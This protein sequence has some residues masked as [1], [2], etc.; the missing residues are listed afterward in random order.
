MLPILFVHWGNS[1]YL[2]YSIYQARHFN[3]ESRII[4][5]GD[6]SNNKYKSIEHYNL[7]E[8]SNSADNFERIYKHMC[9]FSYYYVLF[10]F[11]RWFIIKDFLQRNDDIS[12]FIIIDS[13]VLIYCNVSEAFHP[14]LNNK[15]TIH[16]KRGP[17][18]TYMKN[19]N[20][21]IEFCDFI[22]KL[23]TDKT[24]FKNLLDTYEHYKLQKRPG[25]IDDMYALYEFSLAFPD[26]IGNTAT[27]IHD[28]TFDGTL[29]TSEGFEFNKKKQIKN[30]YWKK[31][32]PYGNH[33]D[34][35][36]FIRFNAIH[37]QSKAKSLMHR[38]YFGR[39]LFFARLYSEFYYKILQPI[40]IIYSKFR[41]TK[42]ND[43]EITQ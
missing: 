1:D 23:Y 27:I 16:G 18:V 33:L 11:K 42:T 37:F 22:V 8:Y 20:T 26:N 3:P 7:A 5:L 12:N 19:K 29:N 30:I 41:Q 14:F 32:L 31:N 21:I 10:W 40:K 17:H 28:T 38:Y 13:D 15:I 34:K 24:L 35:N 4:L 39:Y 6:K 25:G 36:K 2:K 43:T 9:S